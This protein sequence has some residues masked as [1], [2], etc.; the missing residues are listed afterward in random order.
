MRLFQEINNSFSLLSWYAWTAERRGI[1]GEEW[2]KRAADGKWKNQGAACILPCCCFLSCWYIAVC[3]F[4]PLF[5]VFYSF[6]SQ[7]AL[8]KS[9]CHRLPLASLSPSSLLWPRDG[10]TEWLIDI[11]RQTKGLTE[12]QHCVMKMDCSYYVNAGFLQWMTRDGAVIIMN[13]SFF[14]AFNATLRCL[15]GCVIQSV[16]EGI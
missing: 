1:R 10:H 4:L 2:E 8:L 9:S 3:V 15:I 16:D 5:S 7:L 13:Y 11:C 12:L 14:S 6:E